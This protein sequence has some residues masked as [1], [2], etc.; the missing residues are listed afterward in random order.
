M[1][2]K[3]FVDSLAIGPDEPT[4]EML[5][6]L[7]AELK[8]R[9]QAASE[10]IAAFKSAT[11][12]C[13]TCLR[14]CSHEEIKEILEQAS[15]DFTNLSAERTEVIK[16]STELASR[17]AAWHEKQREY[18]TQLTQL[19]SSLESTIKDLDALSNLEAMPDTTNDTQ[20]KKAHA[21]FT[22]AVAAHLKDLTDAETRYNKLD[23]EVAALSAKI[24]TAQGGELPTEEELADAK[25]YINIADLDKATKATLEG[26]T[27]EL[28][29]RLVTERSDLEEIK[30]SKERASSLT[31]FCSMLD[32]ARAL[33]HRDAFPS[34]KIKAFVDKMLT[35]ANSYLEC[36]HAGFSMSYST[37]GFLAYFHKTCKTMRADRLSGGEKVIFAL[38]FRFAV[39]ELHTDTGFL[40]L[41]EPTVFLDDAHIIDVVN[42]LALVKSKLVPRVQL[43]VVT[44]DE[45]LAAVADSVFQVERH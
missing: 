4:T 35:G 45:R 13:P 9:I 39:N 22:S 37:D 31:K 21:R 6:E 27:K 25:E 30:K 3:V 12:V 41:D 34:G 20:M 42:A 14:A 8:A 36:M 29:K 16:M 33:L 19:E 40:V 1:V 32:Q 17:I 7:S 24:K 15:N 28:T 44:H 38:A 18:N 26:Q 11:A 43:I 10:R 2:G 5:S 23:K